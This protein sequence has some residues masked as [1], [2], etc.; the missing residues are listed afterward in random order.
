LKNAEAIENE[1][2]Q[3]MF[4]I[5]GYPNAWDVIERDLDAA[6]LQSCGRKIEKGPV[7]RPLLCLRK[8]GGRN[9]MLAHQ[10]FISHL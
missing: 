3:Q 6:R 9:K 5:M 8:G 1:R 2:F 7:S 4:R 10:S